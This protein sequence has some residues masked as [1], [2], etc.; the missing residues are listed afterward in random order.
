M[1]D[2]EIKHFVSSITGRSGPASWGYEPKLDKA[3]Y[4]LQKQSHN[5]MVV[6]TDIE[7]Y[8]VIKSQRK[9]SDLL[10][11]VNLT[12]EGTFFCGTQNL[13]RCGGLR[14]SGPCKHLYLLS[15]VL[16]MNGS[17]VEKLISWY[18]SARTHSYTMSKEDKNEMKNIFE[19]YATGLTG[20][21]EWREIETFPEDYLVLT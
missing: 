2:I 11:A 3:L 8:G 5:L 14:G 15:L 12:S 9:S 1:G 4:M 13:R 6:E 20:E 21:V 17:S 10:Y 16:L 18:R 19:E 7:V